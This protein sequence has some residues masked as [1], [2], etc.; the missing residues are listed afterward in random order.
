GGCGLCTPKETGSSIAAEYL[1]IPAVTVAAPTF[2]NQVYSTAVTH[3]VAVPRAATYPGAFSAH[4]PDDWS[5]THGRLCGHRPAFS[6]LISPAS[7]VEPHPP[8]AQNVVSFEQKSFSFEQKS[9]LFEQK[10]FLLEQK[11]FLFEGKSLLFE[12]KSFLLE[13]KSFLLEGKSLLL[14]GKSFLLEGKS[15]SLERNAVSN[16][17]SPLRRVAWPRAREIVGDGKGDADRLLGFDVRHLYFTGGGT[18]VTA[19]NRKR[20]RKT[21]Q[22]QVNE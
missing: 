15:R 18:G 8:P 22:V 1:G 13:Q 4:S 11:S 20:K 7:P 9:L 2:V 17:H 14:E 21:G 6:V 12:Q 3:G 5:A 19:E 16:N 10:S